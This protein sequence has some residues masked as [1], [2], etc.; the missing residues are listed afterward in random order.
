VFC[1]FVDNLLSFYQWTWSIDHGCWKQSCRRSGEL[2]V[3]TESEKD[4]QT[5]AKGLTVSW[6]VF[7]FEKVREKL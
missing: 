4:V 3:Q 2:G 5:D 7:L 6:N 1:P